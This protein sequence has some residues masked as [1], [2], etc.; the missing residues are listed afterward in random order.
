M[1]DIKKFIASFKQY[2]AIGF[3]LIIFFVAVLYYIYKQN[4]GNTGTNT[5]PDIPTYIL[6]DATTTG[7]TTGSGGTPGP[8]PP[9]PPSAHCQFL[10][11]NSN[12]AKLFGDANKAHT[13][14]VTVPNGTCINGTGPIIKG[15]TNKNHNGQSS[16][17]WL[18]FS[19][20]GQKG[21]LSLADLTLGSSQTPKGASVPTNNTDLT[22]SGSTGPGE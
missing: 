19:F 21:F 2:P 7:T 12:G 14:K 13:S 16:D 5:Q 18:P 15:R 4:T 1:S 22:L 11:D 10:V 6:Y 9:G 20:G 8:K 3:V 17:Q